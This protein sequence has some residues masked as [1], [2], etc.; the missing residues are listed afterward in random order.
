MKSTKTLKTILMSVAAL[1]VPYLAN[2]TLIWDDGFQ[3]TNGSV[4]TTN[5]LVSGFNLSSSDGYWIRESGTATPSDLYVV[6]SNLQVTA[7]GGSAVSRQDDCNRYFATTAGTPQSGVLATYGN[8]NYDQPELLYASFTVM[9]S[10]TISNNAALPN[11]GG[12]Y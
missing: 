1:T 2:A 7:T 9:C 8:T 4:A 3:Y 11:G 10:T 12:T 5:A 6:N